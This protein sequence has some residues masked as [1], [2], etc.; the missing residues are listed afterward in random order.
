MPKMPYDR[1]SWYSAVEPRY[2]VTYTTGPYGAYAARR[3]F[4]TS[5][6]EIRDIT[7]ALVALTLGFWWVIYVP[8]GRGPWFYLG[9]AALSVVAGFF[10][11]EMSHKFVARRY[12][13]W[14]EFR[15]DYRGLGLMLVVAYFGFLFAAP[16]AVMIFGNIS[17]EQNGKISLAGPGSNLLVAL[18]CLPFAFMPLAGVSDLIGEIAFRLYFFNV[19]LAAFNMI[20]VSPLDG[21]KIWRWSRPVYVGTLLAAGM[22]F[23]L[24]FTGL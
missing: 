4:P 1:D 18:A 5:R 10:I 19:F 2:T 12:G 13:C 9:L 7:A 24:A 14:A 15:A 6:V 20:P 23:I 3:R 11:H 17:R 16:G 21:S 22:L 8:G